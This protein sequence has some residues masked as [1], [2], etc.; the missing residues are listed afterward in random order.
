MW[1]HSVQASVVQGSAALQRLDVI[2]LK[3]RNI[4]NII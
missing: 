2:V 4:I 3:K 1:A